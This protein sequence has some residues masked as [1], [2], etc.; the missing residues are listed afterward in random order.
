[1]MQFS[2]K[3]SLKNI[4]QQLIIT[5]YKSLLPHQ[6]PV[7]I[8]LAW[9]ILKISQDLSINTIFDVGANIG[10][11]SLY[12][13]K[14]F[15]NADIMAFEPVHNT[16]IRLKKNTADLPQVS[17]FEHAFGS[18]AG[19]QELYLQSNSQLNSLNQVL[20]PSNSKSQRIEIKTIEQFCSE[21]KIETID[22]LK[23][24]TEGFD[25]EVIQGAE[26]YLNENK[27]KLILSE[28]GFLKS[29]N[30]HTLFLS[31][32]DYLLTKGFRFYGMYDLV[33]HGKR[34]LGACHCN[35]LFINP[36]ACRKQKMS[37]VGQSKI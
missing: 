4:I 26:K 25:L 20:N 17:C 13:A 15:P 29:D 3:Q 6:F 19:F 8:D 36:V 16:F 27:I 21:H 2:L 23:T 34:P 14:S 24:D 11:T 30:R 5:Q 10:Q 1:M 33:H 32:F 9:D 31:I 28:V 22:I 12:F 35:V 7:G 18:V 37:V